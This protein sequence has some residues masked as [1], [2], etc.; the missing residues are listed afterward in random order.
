ME[1]SSRI[2]WET[3]D[4]YGKDKDPYMVFN[5]DKI[6]LKPMITDEYGNPVA[7]HK[8]T[9]SGLAVPEDK[10]PPTA[11]VETLDK[12]EVKKAEWLIGGYIPLHQITTIGGDGG[13][14]KTTMWAAILAAISSGRLTPFE[15]LNAQFDFIREPQ[16]VMFFSS[17]DPVAE[18][19]KPKI[20]KHGGIM[21]NIYFMDLTDDRFQELQ[22]GGEL[23]EALI[24]QYRPAV[25]VFDPIQSF[26]PIDVQMGS[27]NQMRQTLAPLVG[28]CSKYEV[29]ILLI[30]HANKSSNTWGRKRLADSA[31]L[32]DISRAV[33]LNG[34]LKN[35]L[36]Y[37]SQEKNNY[38]P[39]AK[40]LF[41]S[42]EGGKLCPKGFT[43][44]H[45]RDFVIEDQYMTRQAPA[46]KEAK[47]FI[48]ETL[49]EH[50][51]S[52]ENT[53]LMEFAG[54]MDISPSAMKK[55]KNELKKENKIEL[56]NEGYGEDKKYYVH[57]TDGEASLEP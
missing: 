3:K 7:R 20:S 21:E 13:S 31:D 46:K 11:G 9:E 26:I 37:T 19:L 34:K 38:A 41:F 1:Y 14:A 47:E 35:G 40:T 32:W 50:G 30:A 12:V 15:E 42:L 23:L 48:I 2:E 52:I 8:A 18:V 51:G 24:S 43:D 22:F 10:P 55:A 25:A 29:T 6:P 28:L 27:R 49:Q 16:K 17:E 5:G 36:F 57:Y 54:V 56:K 53:E 45:D 33:F 44:K 4:P 39:L